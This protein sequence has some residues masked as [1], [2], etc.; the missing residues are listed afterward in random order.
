MSQSTAEI[1][2]SST[3]AARSIG[4]ERSA[5]V[6]LGL[7]ALL[8]G[9]GAFVVGYGWLGEFRAQ[10]PVVDPL[11]V[12]WFG[13][14]S[15]IATPVG[16]VLGVALVGL[17][18]WAL[19]VMLR[20]EPRPDIRL[21]R[22]RGRHLTVSGRALADVVREDAE[23]VTGVV[24]ARARMSGSARKPALRLALSLREGTDV[25]QVWDELDTRVLSRARHA[26]G[27]ETLPTAIRLR[28]DRAPRQ[29]AR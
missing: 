9:A 14:Y 5:V 10:R 23:K 24:R 16:I 13:Q 3:P 19:A 7:L 6:L 29:R 2:P 12:Q 15:Q 4:L 20:P 26:L 1:R 21:E 22:E 11:V 28:L 18:L 17:G 8:L 25:R 27:V